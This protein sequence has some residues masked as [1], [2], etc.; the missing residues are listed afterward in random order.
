MLLLSHMYLPFLI[1]FYMC[2]DGF[3]HKVHQCFMYV[4][5]MYANSIKDKN[6]SNMIEGIILKLIIF[7]EKEIHV[8]STNVF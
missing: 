5:C 7:S 8:Y 3:S 2:K 4:I 1:S 6:F